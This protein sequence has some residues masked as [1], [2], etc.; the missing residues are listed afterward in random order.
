MK[1]ISHYLIFLVLGLVL[2][3]AFTFR[4]DLFQTG[5]TQLDSENIKSYSQDLESKTIRV[6]ERVGE[7]VVSI[8]VETKKRVGSYSGSPFDEFGDDLF[9]RFFEEFFGSMPEREFKSQGLGSGVIIDKEGYIL[10]NEH[11]VSGADEIK[12]RLSDGREFD[13]ELKGRDPRIDLAVIKIEANDLP[14]ASLGDSDQLRIGQ[15][16]LAVGNPFAF[17]IEGS[18]GLAR[19]YI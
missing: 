11:V 15:W 7:A 4:T 13:A 6:S 3:V 1:K 18:Q 5:Y 2:G 9:S 14:I 10:T 8:S 16:V 17:A 12:V 19:H